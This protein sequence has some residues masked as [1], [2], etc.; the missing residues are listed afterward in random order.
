MNLFVSYRRNDTEGIAGRLYDR[1]VDHYDRNAVFIDV[2][3]VPIGVDFHDYLDESVKQ[4]D[5]M[6]VLIGSKWL[7]A[8][9]EHSNRRLVSTKDFVR[10]EIELALKHETKLVPVLIGSTEM[11]KE[12]ELPDSIKK[13]VRRNGTTIDAGRFFN[14]TVNALIADLDQDFQGM[15]GK[16]VNSGITLKPVSLF[17]LA[18]VMAG[19]A[20]IGWIGWNELKSGSLTQ[21]LDQPPNQ[22]TTPEEGPQILNLPLTNSKETLTLESLTNGQSIVLIT[23]EPSGA[24][25]L[26]NGIEMGNTPLN[27][28]DITAGQYELTLRSPYHQPTTTNIEILEDLVFK[29]NYVLTVGRGNLTVL[30]APVGA[31]ISLNDE[32]TNEITPASFI[33]LSSGIYKIKISHAGYQSKI[34]E[35]FEVFPSNTTRLM[36][37]L[38]KVWA[39]TIITTPANARITLRDIEP[40]YSAGMEL[41]PGNYVVEVSSRYYHTVKETIRITDE[42]RIAKISLERSHYRLTVNTEP[43]NARVRLAGTSESFSSGGTYLPPGSY[44]IEVS[45]SGFNARRERLTLNEADR[46]VTIVLEPALPIPEM[47]IIPAGSF[48]MGGTIYDELP[49]HTVRISRSFGLSRYEVTFAQYDAYAEAT[50]NEK[51]DDE[52]WGRGNRPVINVRWNDVQGYIRWLNQYTGKSYRLPSESEWEYAVRAGTSTEYGWGNNI[53]HGNTNYGS[54]DCCSGL[55]A[56]RDQWVNTAPVGSFDANAFGLYDMHGNVWEWVQDCYVD[57]YNEAPSD[58]RARE[59]GSCENRVLRGGSWYTIPLNLRSA[60]R[61]WNSPDSRNFDDGFRLAQDL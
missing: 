8:V 27:R 29:E 38:Q 19:V 3:S 6:L 46:I 32:P 15:K 47:V 33:D 24:T 40:D 51:P 60:L 54:D 45:A 22:I 42:D 53:S 9:D 4:C 44:D 41:V 37:S 25:V 20:L 48:Q 43:A 18:L 36:E 5:V 57:N 12:S 14:Q 59:G 31:S 35:S 2:D 56:G 13:L 26:I 17:A 21:W 7:S 52:G 16:K 23:S 1:L 58:G 11:P 61:H 50:G 49:V 10:V 30:S 28:Q 55:A 34:L 39:L